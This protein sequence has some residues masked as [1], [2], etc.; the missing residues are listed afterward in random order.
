MD[1]TAVHVQ[2]SLGLGPPAKYL[3]MSTLPHKFSGCVLALSVANPSM[4]KLMSSELIQELIEETYVPLPYLLPAST[5]LTTSKRLTELLV[6][7]NEA[8]QR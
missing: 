3:V 1:L 2:V 8:S 7:V 4:V 5:S 6:I